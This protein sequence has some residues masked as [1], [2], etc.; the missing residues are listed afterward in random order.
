L[1]HRNVR[2]VTGKPVPILNGVTREGTSERTYRRTH[3][4]LTF[5]GVDLQHAPY[6]LWMQLGELQSKIED[7]AGTPLRPDV[8]SE[9]HTT[10][11]VKG[12]HATSAIEGNTLTEEQVRARIEG[13]LDLPRSREYLGREIDNIFAGYDHVLASAIDEGGR[14]GPDEIRELNRLVLDGLELEEDVEAGAYRRHR[15]VVGRYLGAPAE[16]VGHLVDRLCDWLNGPDLQAG[17]EEL[18]TA[19]A[20]IRAAVAHV[21]LAWI[22]PFGDGNGRTARLV[23]YRLLVAAG[24]P[25]PAAHLLSNHYNLTRTDYYRQLDRTS[26]SGGDL[27]PFLGYAVQG[28]VDQLR[29]QVEVVKEQQLD[30]AWRSH[31]HQRFETLSGP[32]HTRCRHLVLDLSRHEAPVPRGRLRDV[33]PRVAQAY[34]GRTDKTLARDMS[35]LLEM[36]LVRRVEDG[37]VANR[38]AILAFLPLRLTRPS[39]APSSAPPP[40][41]P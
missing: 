9:L 23:E 33:S 22:H 2:R 35:S 1:G 25:T 38:E 7:L 11:V 8:A 4:W 13:R 26:R 12:V 19:F 39:P 37:Y 5:A 15:V 3:P 6:R 24:V 18:A 10:Y 27:V 34:A 30:V 36:G 21:Y 16:D 32:H 41:G 17:D 31:V 29:E 20:I 14:L 40:G 28:F